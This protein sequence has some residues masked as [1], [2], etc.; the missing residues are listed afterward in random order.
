MPRLATLAVVAASALIA[1]PATPALASKGH[2]AKKH[3]GTT[4]KTLNLKLG[5]ELG[6][7]A[8]GPRGVV[9]VNGIQASAAIV[10]VPP[11][12]PAGETQ[13]FGCSVYIP[14]DQSGSTGV[15]VETKPATLDIVAI[16]QQ[17]VNNAPSGPQFL[18]NQTTC[19][20]TAPAGFYA[21]PGPA[22][23]TFTYY[24]S[25]V[26]HS[27]YYAKEGGVLT[28]NSD[29]TFSFVCTAYATVPTPS[30]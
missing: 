9:T 13:G 3:K 17:V 8:A 21:A 7:I 14:T 26:T 1:I 18:F 10:A 12:P 25:C 24:T 30:V 5:P 20:G 4:H 29:G 6:M 2:G 28:L 19:R 23:S 11:T 16:S 22:T 27:G 15:P